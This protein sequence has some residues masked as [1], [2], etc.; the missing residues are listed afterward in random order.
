[1]R[2]HREGCSQQAVRIDLS[3]LVEDSSVAERRPQEDV[4]VELCARRSAIGRPDGE[5]SC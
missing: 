3:D 4:F 2:R 1:M 5:K